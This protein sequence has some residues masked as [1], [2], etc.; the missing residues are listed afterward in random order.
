MSSKSKFTKS[1]IIRVFTDSRIYGSAL[2]DTAP[3]EEYAKDVRIKLENTM[4]QIDILDIGKSILSHA[5]GEAI[6]KPKLQD[7]TKLHKEF[8]DV[9]KINYGAV[10]IVTSYGQL[11][12]AVCDKYGNF[13]NID[14]AYYAIPYF[15]ETAPVSKSTPAPAPAPTSADVAVPSAP[16]R[17]P[18]RGFKGIKK[19]VSAKADMSDAEIAA[20]ETAAALAALESG[21]ASK[22]TLTMADTT[23]GRTTVQTEGG[24]SLSETGKCTIVKGTAGSLKPLPL[25]LCNGSRILIENEPVDIL[26][27]GD[28]KDGI[29]LIKECSTKFPHQ[30]VKVYMIHKGSPMYDVCNNKLDVNKSGIEPLDTGARVE[31]P[32]M[33]YLI[34]I[35]PPQSITHDKTFGAVP[36]FTL[37]NISVSTPN[38]GN[39]GKSDTTTGGRNTN[40][41]MINSS[42]KVYQYYNFLAKSAETEYATLN[43]FMDYVH[44]EYPDY[45]DASRTDFMHINHCVKQDSKKGYKGVCNVYVADRFYRTR[46]LG[47][48][49][50]GN[51]ATM[52]KF[53]HDGNYY[54]ISDIGMNSYLVK[55]GSAADGTTKAAMYSRF[56][57]LAYGLGI[58]GQMLASAPV[59]SPLGRPID[60]RYFYGFASLLKITGSGSSI[61]LVMEIGRS[62]DRLVKK[63]PKLPSSIGDVTDISYERPHMSSTWKIGDGSPVDIRSNKIYP[64]NSYYPTDSYPI[65]LSTAHLMCR[66]VPK[67]FTV[68]FAS[69]SEFPSVKSDQLLKGTSESIR[70]ANEAAIRSTN[71]ERARK[72]KEY[73]DTL[74]NTIKDNFF[75]SQIVG[76]GNKIELSKKDVTIYRQSGDTYCCKAECQFQ[77]GLAAEIMCVRMVDALGMITGDQIKNTSLKYIFF[78]HYS[79]ISSIETDDSTKDPLKEETNTYDPRVAPT[80]IYFTDSTKGYVPYIEQV[81]NR[82]NNIKK[83][84]V[85]PGSGYYYKMLANLESK[86]KLVGKDPKA[87]GL[88]KKK[89]GLVRDASIYVPRHAIRSEDD[90]ERGRNLS[91]PGS[92][93][94]DFIASITSAMNV[95]ASIN[96]FNL[97]VE[98]GL[99]NIVD[100]ISKIG[101]PEDYYE[102]VPSMYVR[103][104]SDVYYTF[105]KRPDYDGSV[106]SYDTIVANMHR[107]SSLSTY[108]EAVALLKPEERYTKELQKLFFEKLKF[109]VEYIPLVHN[110][111]KIIGTLRINLNPKKIK[112]NIVDPTVIR[113]LVEGKG[114]EDI[115]Q[116]HGVIQKIEQAFNTYIRQ[117]WYNALTSAIHKVLKFNPDASP[118][119]NDAIDAGPTNEVTLAMKAFILGRMPS[120]VRHA[121][122][123]APAG[124]NAGA[125][126][127]APFLDKVWKSIIRMFSPRHKSDLSENGATLNDADLLHGALL[128]GLLLSGAHENDVQAGSS[129]GAGT[130]IVGYASRV[131]GAGRICPYLSNTFQASLKT[132]V[133][134]FNNA[135]TNAATTEAKFEGESFTSKIYRNLSES[136]YAGI[137]AKA[138]KMLTSMNYTDMYKL[139]SKDELET[140]KSY[141]SGY[142]G[143]AFFRDEVMQ[144][145]NLESG[146][147]MLTLENF[148]KYVEFPDYNGCLTYI[149]NFVIGE[150]YSSEVIV[151]KNNAKKRW[152]DILDRYKTGSLEYVNEAIK[153]AKEN[154]EAIDRQLNFK[155]NLIICFIIRAVKHITLHGGSE[156]EIAKEIVNFAR[157]LGTDEHVK[158]MANDGIVYEKFKFEFDVSRYE[159]FNAFIS[160]DN[161]M[162]TLKFNTLKSNFATIA[163]DIYSEIIEY[164]AA[165]GIDATNELEYKSRTPTKYMNYANSKLNVYSYVY[166]DMLLNNAKTNSDE[167]KQT[168]TSM[169]SEEAEIDTRFIDFES[170]KRIAATKLIKLNNR[171]VVE[172]VR[173]IARILASDE[174]K[175]YVATEPTTAH[176]ATYANKLLEIVSDNSRPD[177]HDY[178]VKRFATMASIFAS[179]P[180]AAANAWNTT[181]TKIFTDQVKTDALDA[182]IAGKS[183]FLAAKGRF[184]SITNM[185]NVRNAK[186]LSGDPNSISVVALIDAFSGTIEDSWGAVMAHRHRTLTLTN[187]VCN[188]NSKNADELR[189]KIDSIVSVVNA[190]YYGFVYIAACLTGINIVAS[191]SDIDIMSAMDDTEES[192]MYV[193]ELPVYTKQLGSRPIAIDTFR[194]PSNSGSGIGYG[195]S[196]SA[197]MH[198]TSEKTHTCI[199]TKMDR[200]ITEDSLDIVEIAPSVSFD[201]KSKFHGSISTLIE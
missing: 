183:A 184:V 199:V 3:P 13:F 111:A 156:S 88:L 124:A 162:D 31:N 158:K 96:A 166:M 165:L 164:F 155:S 58:V 4:R 30:N 11:D 25:Y 108:D 157:M 71:D 99:D 150:M 59:A 171:G 48:N 188:S 174:I 87:A 23:G 136:L 182:E 130:G 65:E 127:P 179:G 112:M 83:I 36:N 2:P 143:H 148:I 6:H 91:T 107:F 178:I 5:S 198:T 122:T 118:A 133:E 101:T 145:V 86:L 100:K 94:S 69:S 187:V 45:G 75:L 27:T 195:S 43:P 123:G 79:H 82:F 51:I 116:L 22:G 93:V 61:D 129:T 44:T 52:R 104:P 109:I 17:A 56:A 142:S 196:S 172:H 64:F 153:T 110:T 141:E 159:S 35:A 186:P 57:T 139:L 33:Y 115:V 154:I 175:A 81:Y 18:A 167:C 62:I 10:R 125:A 102:A 76:P 85:A 74:N 119:A 84:Y 144:N 147:Y 135:R 54:I 46:I 20:A 40:S 131:H 42:L 14:N 114:E 185:I 191:Q 151:S 149:Y 134:G 49:G 26:G 67:T 201:P 168:V 34:S 193:A 8:V 63:M 38:G 15:S 163:L 77:S 200:H 37:V 89:I 50:W 194:T 138:K 29:N 90:K 106:M 55:N 24:L 121:G 128:Y 176:L 140:I 78:N 120:S 9:N 160:A 97:L 72:L 92:V 66:T 180:K 68:T 70:L 152:T 105:S 16:T 169:F 7:N 21:N 190:S 189:A 98:G 73:M 95:G 132:L 170:I 19:T 113:L 137:V 12:G 103:S 47:E 146:S 192:R 41:G 80:Y 173:A 39:D 60:M 126:A 161:L 28:S 117:V 32:P 53:R 181:S 177:V 1:D 197:G